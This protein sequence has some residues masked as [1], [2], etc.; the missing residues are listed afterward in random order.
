MVMECPPNGIIPPLALCLANIMKQ[1]CPTKPK[2]VA[3]LAY[4][5]KN[6]KCMI[7]VV[8]MRPVVLCFNDIESCQFWHDEV[9]LEGKEYILEESEQ[10]NWFFEF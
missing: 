4:V 5:V 8:L 1:R 9:A 2:V 3:S 6:F 10:A 7:E